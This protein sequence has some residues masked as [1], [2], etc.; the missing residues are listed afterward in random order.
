MTV[1]SVDDSSTMRK[2]ISIAVRNLGHE[3]I[4][5]ENGVDALNKLSG[6]IKVN[7]FIIDINMPEMD[8][9]E[10]IE[11]IKSD[12]RLC[13][14]PIIILTTEQEEYMVNEGMSLGANEWMIKPFDP[15]EFYKTISKYSN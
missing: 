10:L 8:G 4:E 12:E 1:M 13:K 6:D 5:A 2:I 7:L 14:I 3:L 15:E 9:L 11:K